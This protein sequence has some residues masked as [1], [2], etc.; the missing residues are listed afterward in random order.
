MSS[1]WQKLLALILILIGAL[2]GFLL[3][4]RPAMEQKEAQE[5]RLSLLEAGVS[6]QQKPLQQLQTN[7]SRKSVVRFVRALA[8][9]ERLQIK[10]L[11]WSGAQL[12]IKTNQQPWRV[13][14]F[15]ERLSRQFSF[16][17]K[18]RIKGP[19]VVAL[20]MRSDFLPQVTLY[21]DSLYNL[22]E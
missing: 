15:A 21:L 8:R 10:D 6:S 16:Q 11:S 22:S 7:P 20:E 3:F 1:W 14:A 4:T 5:E 19:G 12:K 17:E 9:R 13:A 18:S 2:A